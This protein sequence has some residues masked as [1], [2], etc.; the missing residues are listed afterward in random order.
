MSLSFLLV[1]VNRAV[2]KHITCSI[3]HDVEIQRCRWRR[4]TNTASAEIGTV[5][6]F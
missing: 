4:W 1:C 2:N 5:F 3:E 6:G